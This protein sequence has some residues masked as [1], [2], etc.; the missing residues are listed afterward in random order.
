M[1]SN[2]SPDMATTIKT[3]TNRRLVTRKE[4]LSITTSSPTQDNDSNDFSSSTT[5]TAARKRK[6]SDNEY[7]PGRSAVKQKKRKQN[8]STVNKNPAAVKRNEKQS[9]IITLSLSPRN[10]KTLL[11]TKEKTFPPSKAAPQFETIPDLRGDG[12][13][14]LAEL[15][16]KRAMELERLVYKGKQ[17][18]V[19]GW[20]AAKRKRDED[21]TNQVN[22]GREGIKTLL[23]IMAADS[24]AKG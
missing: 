23:G 5:T 9:L 24:E 22:N 10:L 13:M 15:K 1:S 16:A 14:T 6:D 18:P 12:E 21:N 7:E 20:N 11:P 17:V 2:P 19:G 4:Y 8:N 3:R